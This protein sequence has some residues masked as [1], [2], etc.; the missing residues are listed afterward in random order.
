MWRYL[1]APVCTWAAVSLLDPQ[2]LRNA[3]TGEMFDRQI[4]MD[5]YMDSDLNRVFPTAFV[6]TGPGNAPMRA[7][8]V[9]AM[10]RGFIS[11]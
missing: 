1:S 8:L 3:T 7:A 9:R 5:G 4:W 2:S 11:C 6:V 10:H